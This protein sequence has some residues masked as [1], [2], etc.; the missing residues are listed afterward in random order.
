M[1]IIKHEKK[2]NLSPEEIVCSLKEKISTASFKLYNNGDIVGL[3]YKIRIKIYSINNIIYIK[4]K[5]KIG[6]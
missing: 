4:R 2:V 5:L 1:K 6:F 3:R